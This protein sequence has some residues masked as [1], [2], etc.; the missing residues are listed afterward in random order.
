[1]IKKIE[2]FNFFNYFFFQK[3]PFLFFLRENTNRSGVGAL[4][5][6]ASRVVSIFYENLQIAGVGTMN[7]AELLTWSGAQ[8]TAMHH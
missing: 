3:F 8:R 1:M 6:V 5:G 2:I 7:L 4:F